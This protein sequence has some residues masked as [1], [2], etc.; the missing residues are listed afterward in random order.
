MTSRTEQCGVQLVPFKRNR[1]VQPF[2][3]FTAYGSCSGPRCDEC[4]AADVLSANNNRRRG[5]SAPSNTPVT[6]LHN[7]VGG[8][9]AER[10][11]LPWQ[12]NLGGQG[13]M[14]GGTIVAMNVSVLNV[15]NR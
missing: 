8:V 13:I 10:G 4:P 5:R 14:C 7:I 2:S 12:V 9:N 3:K 15:N 6:D 1:K 11:N